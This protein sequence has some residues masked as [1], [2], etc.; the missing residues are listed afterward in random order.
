MGLPSKYKWVIKV[1]LVYL[2]YKELFQ[3]VAS[4]DVG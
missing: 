4:T 3:K 1:G 2:K